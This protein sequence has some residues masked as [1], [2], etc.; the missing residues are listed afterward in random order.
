MASLFLIP[1]YIHSL[2]NTASE[3]RKHALVSN[4]MEVNAGKS[5]SESWQPSLTLKHNHRRFLKGILSNR[6]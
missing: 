5:V 1:L 2:S 3:Q 6:N 4:E